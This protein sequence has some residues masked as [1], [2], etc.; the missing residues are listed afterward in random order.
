M[1]RLKEA[2]RLLVEELNPLGV[3]LFG[4]GAQGL[5]TPENDLDLAILS[6]RTQRLPHRPRPKRRAHGL[7]G[8]P[9]VAQATTGYLGIEPYPPERLFALRGPLSLL[10]GREVDLVDLRQAA[11]PLQAQ[12]AAFGQPLYRAGPEAERFLDLALKA[13]ARLNEERAALLRDVR[14]RGRIYG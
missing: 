8:A 12:V 5:L 13:Y 14:T 11:L 9:V 6:S 10:L 3:Y 4:S 1:E 2:V 7:F